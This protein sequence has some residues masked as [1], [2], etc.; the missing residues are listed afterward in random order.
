MLEELTHRLEHVPLVA[1]E[2]D[3]L[4]P[5]P[6][7]SA[8]DRLGSPVLLRASGPALRLLPFPEFLPHGAAA[9]VGPNS[10]PGAAI[11]AIEREPGLSAGTVGDR[12]EILVAEAG[13]DIARVAH[14]PDDP[15]GLAG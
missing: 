14:H 15:V 13:A 12:D 1:V 7:T 8:G 3:Q 2:R 6:W 4:N 11:L 10:D 9:G 5:F